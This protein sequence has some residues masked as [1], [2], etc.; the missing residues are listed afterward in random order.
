MLSEAKHLK[1]TDVGMWEVMS[2]EWEVKS[3]KW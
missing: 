3:G 2:D 1:M